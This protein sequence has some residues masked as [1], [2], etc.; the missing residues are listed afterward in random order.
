MPSEYVPRCARERDDVYD[1]LDDFPSTSLES[2]EALH[3]SLLAPLERAVG[4]VVAGQCA[5]SDPSEG[6]WGASCRLVR[7]AHARSRRSP[8]T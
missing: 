5:L 6:Y 1:T 3:S 2:V 4:I 7:L 8:R